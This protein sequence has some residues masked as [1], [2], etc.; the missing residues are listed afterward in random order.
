MFCVL[1]P[2]LEQVPAVHL[3]QPSIKRSFSTLAPVPIY[4]TVAAAFR[5]K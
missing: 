2:L 5:L 1:F 4:L 3:R